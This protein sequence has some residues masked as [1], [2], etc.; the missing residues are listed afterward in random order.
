VAQP[1]PLDE[2][3]ASR[4]AGRFAERLIDAAGLPRARETDVSESCEVSH[5][6]QLLHLTCTI[7]GSSYERPWDGSE[8]EAVALADEAAED[9]AYLIT[10]TPHYA[11]VAL[12]TLN[13]ARVTFPHS[14]SRCSSVVRV[15]AETRVGGG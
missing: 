15:W 8:T 4:L 9:T 14:M 12:A 10:Q 1:L 11:W 2:Q 5:D 7:T 3:L 6:G 13:G